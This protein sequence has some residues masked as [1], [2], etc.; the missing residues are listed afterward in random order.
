MKGGIYAVNERMCADLVAAKYG[1]HASTWERSW[2]GVS[3]KSGV[4][5]PGLPILSWW[6]SS[7]PSHATR[8]CRSLP[9]LSIF[10]ALNQKSA[11]RAVAQRLGR[12]YEECNF[13]VAHLGGGVSVGA[14]RSGRVVDVN[15]A[16]NGDGPF[17]P[18]RAGGVPAGQLIGLSQEYRGREAELRK[19]LVGRGGLVAYL[20]TNNLE[21]IRGRIEAGDSHAQEVVEAM[22]YQISREI[23]SHGATLEGRVDAVIL[24]GEWPITGSWSSR[25]EEGSLPRALELF[26]GEREME[27]LAEN[28]LAALTG[29]T[30]VREYTREP[31]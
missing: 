23:A 30:G 25:S 24:T 6:T 22:A 28:A 4:F 27:A 18:E 20:G 16:L 29:E 13:I 12:T 17:S 26:P 9:R 8:G 10:H 1:E 14:H 15:N 31:A 21:E 3:P 7:S 11:A 19:R 2:P 5:P